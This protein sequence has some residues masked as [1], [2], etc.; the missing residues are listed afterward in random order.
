MDT[1][2]LVEVIYYVLFKS[3]KLLEADLKLTRDLLIGFNAQSYYPLGIVTFKRW[4]DSQELVIEFIF[5]NIPFP[6]NAIIG[7]DW[8]A[9]WGQSVE[10]G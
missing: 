2:I 5:V 9:P 4:A 3:L 8:L 10:I 1:Y 6:Y 7:R